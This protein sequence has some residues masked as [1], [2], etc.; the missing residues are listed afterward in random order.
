MSSVNLLVIP[1]DE[2]CCF[3]HTV[4]SNQGRLEM[5]YIANSD[6]FMWWQ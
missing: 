6:Y 4:S 2:Y 1:T 3:W 5:P